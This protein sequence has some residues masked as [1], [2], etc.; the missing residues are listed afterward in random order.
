M[1]EVK[2]CKTDR[3]SVLQ[4]IAEQINLTELSV[5]PCERLARYQIQVVYS[6]RSRPLLCNKARSL[7]I[8]WG[9]TP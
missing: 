1:S 9:P 4:T 2:D 8:F 6:F 7:A 3:M 5:R